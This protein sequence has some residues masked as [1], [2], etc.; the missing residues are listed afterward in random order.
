MMERARLD[1]FLRDRRV[2]VLA[3][4]RDGRPPL[5]TPV[6]YAWDGARMH[7]QV[8]AT[9]TKAKLLERAGGTIRVALT[10]QAEAPP[11]RYAVLYGPA[12]LRPNEPGLRRRLADRYFGRTA[13]GMYVQQ[14][15]A[16]GRDEAK[17]RV[18]EIV[19]DRVMSHDFAPEAGW[20]GR[21]YFALWRWLH[22]VRA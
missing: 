17:L 18:V 11:Y 13:G 20:S 1:A 5:S 4:P 8:E 7:I 2:G 21:L 3:I 22:P 14:E 6:W 16:A 12:T 9:S 15:E 19:P 10:V